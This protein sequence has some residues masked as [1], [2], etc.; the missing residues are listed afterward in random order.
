MSTYDF[1]GSTY[2]IGEWTGWQPERGEGQIFDPDLQCNFTIDDRGWIHNLLATDDEPDPDDNHIH[3][4]FRKK[5]DDYDYEMVACSIKEDGVRIHSRRIMIENINQI[6]G[7][8][9]DW[10]G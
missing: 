4:K 6:T 8:D 7:L 5:G 2:S 10:R 3:I 9:I 1:R